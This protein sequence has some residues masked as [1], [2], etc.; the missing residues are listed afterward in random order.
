LTLERLLQPKS[1]AVF[2]GREAREVVR[3][4]QRMGFAGDI[5]P[6]HPSLEEVRG[7]PCYRSV[8]E[9]PSAPD[10]SFVGVN[11]HLTIDIIRQLSE[12]AAGGAV[13]YASGFGEVD[14][15]AALQD[16]LLKA[17]ETMPILGPNCYGVI[18]YLDG[19]LLWPDQHGSERVE[20]G[21]AILTQ[22]SNIGI[23]LTMQ[24]RGLPIAYLIALGN[25]A[26]TDLAGALDTLIDD[27]RVSAVGLYIEGFTNIP[28]LQEVMRRAHERN[29]PVVVVKS[30]A[31]V[32]GARITRSHTASMAGA[33]DVANALLDRLGMARVRDLDTLVETLKLL[34]VHGPLKGNRLCSMSCSGGEASL[35]A[36]TAVGRRIVF[37][38]LS[39]EQ[40]KAVSQTVHELVSVSNP[41][42]YH[43]FAWN[44]EEELFGTYR[45]MLRC[46]FDLSILVLDFPRLD[47]CTIETWEPA[48]RAIKRAAQETGAPTA[49]L[50]SLPE[51]LPEGIAKELISAGIVPLCGL[52]QAIDAAEAAASVGPGALEVKNN[53]GLPGPLSFLRSKHARRLD[54]Y[55]AKQVLRAAGIAVPSGAKATDLVSLEEK[56]KRLN[57]PLA[58]K[59]CDPDLLHKSEQG[60]V[61]LNIED[62]ATL[63]RV[64]EPLFD[65][66]DTVL[67]EEMVTDAVGEWI[68]GINHDPAI[69]PWMLIGAGGVFAE[70]LSDRAV[71]L[72][73]AET[74]HLER[75]IDSLKISSMMSGYRGLPVGDRQALLSALKSLSD[76][77]YAHS[78]TLIELE[79]NPLL[80]CPTGKGVCAADAVIQQATP[81]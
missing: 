69:G 70:L 60:A 45:A 51:S 40:F 15:G 9:L 10:A 12:R 33:D 18:N 6:V 47:R 26:Q 77:A 4:C 7:L 81:V 65:R 62:M 76:F 11:R 5:W 34:H 16:A 44:K 48:V 78:D 17:A 25:Q 52:R 74:H 50:A 57:F 41:L 55:D 53:A 21:V 66:F 58:L 39:D 71:V 37:P 79:I 8:A 38:D 29:L 13:C 1:I 42:D 49:V 31:S 30:G 46:G 23:N 24:A 36:D 72:L 43:T 73:P 19:A 27:T 22:S 3:Q 14:D 54:E 32:Q 59:G 75:A 63:L 56:A 20:R 67:V 80:I 61:H 35:M 2:G 64:A 28:M 68:V